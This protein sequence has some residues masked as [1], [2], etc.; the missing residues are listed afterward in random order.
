ME[1]HISLYADD[2][3]LYIGNAHTFVGPVMN[4]VEEFGKWS[5]LRINWDKSPMLPF[6][7]SSANISPGILPASD[8][9]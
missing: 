1:E 9:L 3:L 5:G 8:S 6:R 4:I 2:M 7:P